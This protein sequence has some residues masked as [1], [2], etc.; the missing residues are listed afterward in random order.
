MEKNIQEI[1]NILRT[2]IEKQ[3]SLGLA[4]SVIKLQQREESAYILN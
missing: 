2:Y 1:Q 4:C 3:N